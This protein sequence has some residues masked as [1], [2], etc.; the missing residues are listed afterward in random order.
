MTCE[1]WRTCPT[2]RPEAR[3]YLQQELPFQP[4][5]TCRRPLWAGGNREG[6]F[7]SCTVPDGATCKRLA[8]EPKP[9]T[10]PA[11]DWPKAT[12]VQA[13][14]ATLLEGKSAEEADL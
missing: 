5:T 11:A 13:R 4:C 1:H 10:K 2:C 12:A 9:E 6:Y 7:N 8:S 3:D 14:A